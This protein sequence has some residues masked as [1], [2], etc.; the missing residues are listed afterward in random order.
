MIDG[1]YKHSF[2]GAKVIPTL[3]D[4]YK[5]IDIRAIYAKNKDN[6]QWRC[7]FLKV[8]FT[9][10]GKEAIEAIHRDKHGLLS[11]NDS[12]LEFQSECKH[13]TAAES[14]LKEINNM[15]ITINGIKATLHP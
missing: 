7:V 3:R 8:Y 15:N 9:K 12:N 10:D 14:L 4:Q 13:I 6:P 1:F 2:I 5:N 11:T